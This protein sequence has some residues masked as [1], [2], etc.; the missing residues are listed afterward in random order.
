MIIN[1]TQDPSSLND[2]RNYE[3]LWHH[4]HAY[5]RKTRPKP[6]GNAKILHIYECKSIKYKII[7]ILGANWNGA[8]ERWQEQTRTASTKS[9][10]GVA[11]A[12]EAGSG[13]PK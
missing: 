11:F 7:N 12:A 8:R 5:R 3:A 9:Y 10:H 4:G 2:F 6:E 13:D 1:H